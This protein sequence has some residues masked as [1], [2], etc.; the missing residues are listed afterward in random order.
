MDPFS[1]KP[2]S[3]TFKLALKYKFYHQRHFVSVTVCSKRSESV[4]RVV[5][6]IQT[7]SAG[8]L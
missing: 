2:H 6:I 3:E 7:T 4:G 5:S 8:E 1:L